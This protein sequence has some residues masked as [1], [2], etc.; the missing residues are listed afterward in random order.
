MEWITVLIMGIGLDSERVVDSIRNN[1]LWPLLDDLG[2][3]S[4]GEH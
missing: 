1:D 2:N 4:H 3:A